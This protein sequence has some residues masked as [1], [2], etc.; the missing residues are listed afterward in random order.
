MRVNLEKPLQFIELAINEEPTI[1]EMFEPKEKID[2]KLQL[3][4][5]WLQ[6]P[7]W[8]P[9]VDVFTNREIEFDIQ[10]TQ[11]KTLYETFGIPMFAN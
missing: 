10:L 2:N 9:L 1:A 11:I 4:S 3:E 5:L 6:N 7:S 8:L